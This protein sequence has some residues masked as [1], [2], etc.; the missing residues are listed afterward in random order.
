MSAQSLLQ[1]LFTLSQGHFAQS[2]LEEKNKEL[3]K[4][5][6]DFGSETEDNLS[7]CMNVEFG[8]VEK[9]ELFSRKIYGLKLKDTDILIS[10]VF[11]ALEGIGIPNHIRNNF[12][13]LTKQQWDALTRIV[14]LILI[15]LEYHIPIDKMK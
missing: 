10:E 3:I 6:L 11:H 2:A 14:T 8:L 9:P 4:S 7:S 1:H 13:S 12:P 5:L 15:A